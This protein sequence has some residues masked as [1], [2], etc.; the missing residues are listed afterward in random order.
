MC[1]LIIKISGKI[2]TKT[3]TTTMLIVVRAIPSN[4]WLD[5]IESKRSWSEMHN[6]NRLDLIWFDV[7]TIFSPHLHLHPHPKDRASSGSKCDANFEPKQAVSSSITPPIEWK[8]LRKLLIQVKWK[9]N[10]RMMWWWPPKKNWP[11]KM[12]EVGKSEQVWDEMGKWK[13][14]RIQKQSKANDHTRPTWVIDGKFR[15]FSSKR[16]GLFLNF[17]QWIKH[18]PHFAYTKYHWIAWK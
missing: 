8:N 5:P 16:N 15:I 3:T 14:E 1:A 4:S 6:G 7:A 2:E 17:R 11:L 9:K 12:R 10:E 18:K 13:I